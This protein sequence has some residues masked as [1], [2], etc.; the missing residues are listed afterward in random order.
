[1]N[2]DGDEDGDREETGEQGRRGRTRIVARRDV[3]ALPADEE[4]IGTD[5]SLERG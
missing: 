4:F 1:M 3:S 5:H 2:E